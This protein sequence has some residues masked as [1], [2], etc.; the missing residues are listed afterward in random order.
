MQL[1]ACRVPSFLTSI[2]ESRHAW[3]AF[4]VPAVVGSVALPLGPVCLAL[5][6]TLGWPVGDGEFLSSIAK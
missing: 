5:G 6:A 4:G 3:G 2:P 1:L